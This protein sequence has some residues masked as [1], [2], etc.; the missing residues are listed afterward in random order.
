MDT[1][2]L[3]INHYFDVSFALVTVLQAAQLAVYSV[4]AG[5]TAPS[6]QQLL[7]QVEVLSG[8]R[9]GGRD[10]ARSPQEL[11][12]SEDAKRVFEAALTV[13]PPTHFPSQP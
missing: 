2:T 7:M 1:G 9:R 4:C 6:E 5:A 13:H 8:K 10:A 11:P 3:C 12:F